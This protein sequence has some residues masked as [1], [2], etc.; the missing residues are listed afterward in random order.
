MGRLVLHGF[1]NLVSNS[2]VAPREAKQIVEGRVGKKGLV[3]DGSFGTIYLPQK[4][5]LNI[6]GGKN[7]PFSS[8]NHRH[9]H[10]ITSIFRYVGTTGSKQ[11]LPS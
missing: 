2:H 7:S 4:V 9:L 5:S 1:M 11:K 6:A 8:L 10:R 3:L